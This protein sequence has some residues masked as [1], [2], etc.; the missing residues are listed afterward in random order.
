VTDTAN[1]PSPQTAQTK[2]VEASSA[3]APELVA[4]A[5]NLQS[6]IRLLIGTALIG[7]EALV[8]EIEQFERAAETQTRAA[9]V[10]P[11]EQ[12]TDYALFRYF[13]IGLAFDSIR[14]VRAGLPRLRELAYD[15]TGLV[16]WGAAPVLDSRFVRPLRSQLNSVS[17]NLT[18][19]VARLV[20][21]G[22]R[23]EHV[24]RAMTLDSLEHL[25][26]LALDYLATKPE[27]RDLIEQ[28][29][30]S[31]AGEVV[32]SVREGTV[33]ADNLIERLVRSLL[34]RPPRSQLPEPPAVVR[35]QAMRTPIGA[36]R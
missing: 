22:Y 24:S 12:T 23:Q 26:N 35:R 20:S 9:G 19:E 6:L 33:A 1:L 27:I 31:M 30:L 13:L 32:E 8:K 15:V 3:L 16:T 7:T 2:P 21:V 29:G 10:P 11:A 14:Q 28:Q 18:G 36:G 4:Q 17:G 5:D 34:H 25:L